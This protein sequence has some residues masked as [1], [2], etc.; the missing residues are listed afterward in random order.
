M[1]TTGVSCSAASPTLA[2]QP[3]SRV[4][5]ESII[6]S[7]KN[8]SFGAGT[9]FSVAVQIRGTAGTVYA[10]IDHVLASSTVQNANITDLKFANPKLGQGLVVTTNTPGGSVTESVA[11]TGWIEDTNG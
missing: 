7:L 3:Q 2:T 11:A 1:V 4:H 9:Q 6:Y 8:W 5:L 10:N